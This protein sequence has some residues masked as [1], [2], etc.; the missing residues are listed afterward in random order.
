VAYLV[1]RAAAWAE[2]P[3]DNWLAEVVKD[4]PTLTQLREL[5]NLKRDAKSN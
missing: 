3:L 1:E 5:L 2:M 4:P